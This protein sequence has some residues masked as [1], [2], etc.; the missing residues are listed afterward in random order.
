MSNV[1]HFGNT[2]VRNPK[3]IKEGLKVLYNSNLNGNLIGK[4]QEKLFADFLNNAGVIELK[5]TDR[6]YSDMGRKWRACFSQL[7]FITHKFKRSLS[8]GEK[9]KT[10]VKVLKEKSD[11]ELHG[12]PYE[13]TRNG[14]NLLK[15]ETF[16]EEQECILRSLLAYQIPS[17][18]EADKKKVF[19]PFYFI[20]QILS[21]LNELDDKRG[22][23]KTEMAIVQVAHEHSQVDEI[24][25]EI[26]CFR[27][28]YDKVKGRVPKKRKEKELLSNIAEKVNLKANTLK[29]YA[30]VNFRYPR[31]TGVVSYQGKRLIL[32]QKKIEIINLIFS[33]G[34]QLI[35]D[36]DINYLYRLWTGAPLP[37]DDKL[38][39][40]SEIRRLYNILS[41]VS[42]KPDVAIQNLNDFEISELN[43]IRYRLEQKHHQ[44]LEKEYANKQQESD[45]LKEILYYLKELDNQDYPKDE[46]EVE[47]DDGPAYF[48]WSVWRAFLAINNLINNPHEARRFKVDQDFLPLGCAPGGGPDLIFEFENYVLAVEVTLTTSSRQ[49]AAEGEPVRRHVAKIAQ[50]YANKPVYGLFIA[51]SINNNTAETF[52]IGVWYNGD[53]PGFINI[54]PLTLDQFITL[55]ELFIEKRFSSIDIKNILDQCLISRNAHAPKWKEEI[56]EVIQLYSDRI[57]YNKNIDKMGIAAEDEENIYMGN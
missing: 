39:A 16:Q 42:E 51:R 17:K 12:Y 47:I 34:K 29:D 36:N 3:R 7:G 2:T 54:V 6:D 44:Y 18:I 26:I 25:N 41:N 53:N 30:D 1:W 27:K 50:T 46:I 21:K 28:E 20:L 56:G 40:I 24:I 8:P 11:L 37:T 15:A 43:S 55:M 31:L 45:T 57:T 5:N 52:R 49:E 4:K 14:L 35:E 13:I 10:I 23:S 32:N 9:D 22:L 19:K 33:Q 48:E 38:N